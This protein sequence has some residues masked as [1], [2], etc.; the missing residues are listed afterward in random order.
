MS[1]AVAGHVTIVFPSASFTD[2]AGFD[3]DIKASLSSSYTL[4]IPTVT[5]TYDGAD[6]T[7]V[8]TVNKPAVP[9]AYITKEVTR[10]L[11]SFSTM[12]K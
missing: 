3:D 9:E 11:V 6:V 10:L 7:I 4:D 5:H 8:V 2:Y 1:A 12:C